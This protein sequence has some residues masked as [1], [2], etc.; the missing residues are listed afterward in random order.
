MKSK[1]VLSQLKLG[2]SSD[3]HFLANNQIHIRHLLFGYI[4]LLPAS[5]ITCRFDLCGYISFLC[6]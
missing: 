2:T 4:V 1:E 3:H 5:R 6:T